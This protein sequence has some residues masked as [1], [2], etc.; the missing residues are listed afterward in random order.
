M[1]L[2]CLSQSSSTTF[3][4]L[5]KVCIYINYFVVVSFL[6]KKEEYTEQ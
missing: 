4:Y 3:S 2:R 5:S 1:A 6:D